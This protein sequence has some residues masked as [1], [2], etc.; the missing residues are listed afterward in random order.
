MKS[1][2][3]AIPTKIT[4]SPGSGPSFRDAPIA[5]RLRAAARVRCPWWRGPEMA[6]RWL[7]HGAFTHAPHAGLAVLKDCTYC[8]RADASNSATDIIMPAQASCILCHSS[9]GTAPS[10]CLACHSFHAPQTVVNQLKP[11]L[12]KAG[13][14]PLAAC[15]VSGGLSRFLVSDAHATH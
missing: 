13:V 5:T 12:Q 4:P 8:H 10:N 3:P 2:S 9:Q 15:P 7:A 1:S 11:M 6:E 14:P